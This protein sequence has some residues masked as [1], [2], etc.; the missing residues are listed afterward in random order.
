[1]SHTHM[2]WSIDLHE[3]YGTVIVCGE[4]R[5]A[6]V[7][8]QGNDL[9]FAN[10]RMIASAPCMLA[11]LKL[12]EGALDEGTIALAEVRAAIAKAEGGAA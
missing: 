6:S 8:V 10:A 1:M 12:A 4:A 9:G 7:F 5:L 2:P 11:A 3:E